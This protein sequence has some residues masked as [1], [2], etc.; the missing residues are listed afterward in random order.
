MLC[1]KQDNDALGL[2]QSSHIYME[3]NF[4][5]ILVQP[6]FPFSVYRSDVLKQGEHIMAREK[7]PAGTCA[8]GGMGNNE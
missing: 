4:Y 3:Q 6:E 8:L 7:A 1:Y 5:Y 2:W